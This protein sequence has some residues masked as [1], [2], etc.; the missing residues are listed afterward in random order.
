MQF[1]A[2]KSYQSLG[3]PYKMSCKIRNNKYFDLKVMIHV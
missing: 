3:M 2:N 1:L